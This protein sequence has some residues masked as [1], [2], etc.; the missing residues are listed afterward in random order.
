LLG[1]QLLSLKRIFI[2]LFTV[3]L[4]FLASAQNW[5]NTTAGAI[6]HVE[7]GDLDV[8]GNVITV[9]ALVTRTAPSVNI[10]SKHSSPNDLN[11]LLRAGG[12]EMT[13][14]NGYAS[15]V[16]S[17]PLVDNTPYHVAAVYDGATLKYY[18]NGCLTGSTNATG[19]LFQNDWETSIG[20]R[21][22]CECEQ[23]V[24]YIDEVRIW[25]VARTQTEIQANMNNLPSPTTQ[26]GLLS[27]HKF[28][29]SFVNAQGNTSWNGTGIGA[30]PMTTNPFYTAAIQGVVVDLTLVTDVT[31]YNGSDGAISVS[32]S[33]GSG[34]YTY[35]IDGVTFQNSPDFTGL[36]AGTYTITGRTATG[37]LAQVDATIEEPLPISF[38]L[39]SAVDASCN[40]G[41]DGT[42]T[43]AVVNG[44][45]TYSY[46]WSSNNQTTN[47]ATGLAAGTYTV[48]VTDDDGCTADTSYSVG[49]PPAISVTIT[50]STPA[51]CFGGS[52]GTA[53]ASALGGSSPYTYTWDNGETGDFAQFL[54]A[55]NHVVTV[56]DDNGCSATDDVTITEPTELTG[57]ITAQTEPACFGGSDGSA[58]VTAAGGT[59]PYLYLWSNGETG[60]TAVSLGANSYSVTITDN[61][62]CTAVTSVTITQPT[63]LTAVI[64]PFSDISCY[65]G[66]DGFAT[67]TAA[68]GTPGYTYLWP[69]GQTTTTASNLEADFYIVE[70]FDANGCIAT[71]SITLTEPDTII[72]AMQTFTMVSCNG[73]SDAT[74]TVAAQGGTNTFTYA[75]SNGQTNATATGLAAGNYTVT[76]TDG[77][78]CSVQLAH[79]VIEPDV[80]TATIIDSEDVLC[81]GGSDGEAT[82]QALGGF[83]PYSY[84]WS[85][86]GN[87]ATDNNLVAGNNSVSV[88]DIN[89]CIANASVF[90]TEPTQV[91]MAASQPTTICLGSNTTITANAIGGVSPY[92]FSWNNGFVGNSQTVGPNQNTSYYV[93]VRDANNCVAGPDTVQV[94]VRAPLTVTITPSFEIC[95]GES[96]GLQANATGGDS[97]FSY[98]WDNGLGTSPG[99]ITV[100][101]DTTTTYTL[102]VTD[103][104]GTPAALGVVTVTVNPLPVALFSSEDTVGCVPLPV[105]FDN[106]STIESGTITQYQWSFGV[107]ETSSLP[108]PLI[109][110]DV[111]GTYDISLIA[112]SNKGCR[113]TFE[114]LDYIISRPVPVADFSV[115][116]EITP[117]VSPE[118]KFTDLSVGA[119]IW[120]WTFGDGDSSDISSPIH[121]Y[122]D[123]GTYYVYLHVENDYGCFD[124]AFHRVIINPFPT[125]WVPSAFTP[126]A[127]GINDTWFVKGSDIYEFELK[128]Y[129]RWG[130]MMFYTN[131]PFFGWDGLTPA[132]GIKAKQDVYVYTIYFRDE[133][134]KQNRIAGNLTLIR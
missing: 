57:T 113:D 105:Q 96:G 134:G 93:T 54:D 120:E 10:V 13:T 24:G 15:V 74:A 119:S 97:N 7:I 66:N 5:L 30:P 34:P 1:F 52:D 102:T 64:N 67:V 4:P 22:D 42:I 40:G 55:G 114:I 131:D 12:F 89:G 32:A 41:A 88:V 14:T 29:G 77:N 25:N 60:A 78:G 61:N 98:L 130:S 33:G 112:I 100:T 129:N 117:I 37:C 49:E 99:I 103:G 133:A 36:T 91:N 6:R 56:T 31:C 59:P 126:D 70:V 45:P 83:P 16:N 115:D 65:G 75:W 116:P 92:T 46:L 81:F 58:T 20:N 128:I 18:V 121:T 110:Y 53:N 63:Q 2:L 76:I 19:N 107:T 9:E 11:Y 68:G 35:S 38:T 79:T 21:D 106:L 8:P 47:P 72:A 23:F 111:P 3:S 51:L 80:L 108:N 124:D 50:A 104:C 125:I 69:D 48:T 26:A 43:V 84:S 109:V 28:E 118:V 94:L 17:F 87:Q 82:V 39:V 44:F 132:T 73:G 95:E 90:L 86:G 27:Y 71:G 122:R 123:T 62:N 85:S 127:D 101:P